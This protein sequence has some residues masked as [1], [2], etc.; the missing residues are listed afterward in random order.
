MKK[1]IVILLLGGAAYWAWTEH[2]DWFRFSGPQREG[3]GTRGVQR[4]TGGTSKEAE[5]I[6]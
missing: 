1:L 3:S 5:Q 2:R 6:K 4:L